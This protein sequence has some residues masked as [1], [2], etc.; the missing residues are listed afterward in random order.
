MIRKLLSLSC[1]FLLSLL[2]GATFSL[3]AQRLNKAQAEKFA[4]EALSRQAALQKPELNAIW[5]QKQVS[6]D[7][8]TMKFQYRI[9]GEKPAGGRSLYISM[10]GGG[11]T[12]VAVNDQQWKNQISLYTP[13]EGVYVAPRAPTNNWNL[14][15]EPHI[16]TLFAQLIKAAILSEDVNPDKIYLTGYSAGGDGTFQMAPRMAD[17]WAAAAMM[18]GHPGDAEALNLRNLPFA[19]Y[20]GGKD[21]A[22]QRNELA[23]VWGK[24]LDSL[25]Q[26]NPGSFRHDLH[27]YPDMPHWMN[28]KDTIAIPWLAQFSRN[29]LPETVFWVQDD[30]HRGRFYW[31][32]VPL[33]EHIKT[34][35]KT[36]V[37]ISGNDIIITQNDNPVLFIYLNDRMLNLDKK[38]RVMQNGNI[39]FSGKVHRNA[40]LMEST[41]ADLDPGHVFSARLTITGKT[42]TSSLP[43]NR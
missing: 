24:K 13:K 34:G 17:H 15:H 38:V 12:A 30:V 26:A 25:E 42:V 36:M 20:M 8:F 39:L 40:K 16:D 4:V 3:Q 11:G 28:R 9:L 43:G 21:A 14:W 10:H 31:L 35:A 37:T 32:G 6:Y 1:F 19:I 41:A 22:Y 2:L 7:K 23:T 5:Q 33:N 18:A 29:A 27:I